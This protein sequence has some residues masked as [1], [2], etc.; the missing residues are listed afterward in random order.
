V[1]FKDALIGFI[2]LFDNV[3]FYS[4]LHNCWS[5]CYCK[6]LCCLKQTRHCFTVSSFHIW[7]WKGSTRSHSVENSF[8]KRLRYC[9]KADRGTDERLMGEFG[10]EEHTRA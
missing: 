8:W 1:V 3:L 10:A 2:V 7:S 5:C 4:E 9:R 6:I